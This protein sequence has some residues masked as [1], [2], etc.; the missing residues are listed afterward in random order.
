[1]QNPI[2]KIKV[3]AVGCTNIRKVKVRIKYCLGNGIYPS[4]KE[5][6]AYFQIL[7]S[8][9]LCRLLTCQTFH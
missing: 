5:M 4:E 8:K 7:G 6:Q 1:M 3:R 9:D 2:K